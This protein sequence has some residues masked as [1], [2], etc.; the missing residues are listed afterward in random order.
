MTRLAAAATATLI[1]SVTL[2]LSAGAASVIE[3]SSGNFYFEDGSVG[4]GQITMDAGDQLRVRIVEGTQ[5]TVD[6][7]E[8]G[9][10]SSK[11]ATGDVF[12]TP[13]LTTPGTYTLF[14]RTHLNRGHRTTLVVQGD[15]PTTTATTT[16]TLPATTTTVTPTTIGPGSTTTTAA[17]TTTT[18]TSPSASTPDGQADPNDQTEHAPNVGE[19]ADLGSSAPGGTATSTTTTIRR[20]PGTTLAA[21]TVEREGLPLWTRSLWVGLFALIPI[22]VLTWTATRRLDS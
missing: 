2:A 21:G 13:P 8:F 19:P 3:V 4:D 16:T 15:T 22:G 10:S 12:V 17:A 18:D 11:L 20:S 1:A 14:C 7:S 5:H 6:I 9:I